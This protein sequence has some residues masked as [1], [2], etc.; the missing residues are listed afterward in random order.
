MNGR[1]CLTSDLWSNNGFEYQCITAHFIHNDWKLNKRIISFKLIELPYTG[2]S[3]GVEIRNILYEWALQNKIFT[4][5]LDNASY[6]NQIV[7]HLKSTLELLVGVD[8]FHV[9]CCAIF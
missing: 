4:I 8:L 7:A 1:V 6:Y 2:H 9:C 3:L 5:S